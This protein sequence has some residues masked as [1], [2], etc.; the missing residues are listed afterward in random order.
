MRVTHRQN[1]FHRIECWT[2][3]H[4]RRAELWEVGTYI[5]VEHHTD[6]PICQALNFQIKYLES[7]ECMKDQ[8]EQES[9][10]WEADD[11]QR[12]RQRPNSPHSSSEPY[13]ESPSSLDSASSSPDPASGMTADGVEADN[14]TAADSAFLNHLDALW[15][16]GLGNVDAENGFEDFFDGNDESEVQDANEDVHGFQPYLPNPNQT[17]D[18]V[19]LAD[20]AHPATAVP[21]ADA[22]RSAAAAPTAD[23]L[24]NSYIRVV[25]TNG[26]HHLAMVT[27]QCQGEHRIPLDLVTNNLLP[28]SFT[29]IRTLFTVQVLDYFRLCNLELKA[30]A[31]QFYQLIRRVTSPM[32]PAEVVNLYH[33]LRRMSRL[34]RWM[35]RLKWAGYGHNQRDPLTPEPGTLANFC[36]ACP[37][38]GINIPEN[39]KDDVNR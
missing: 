3:T 14:E 7:F 1:P 20:A 26:I 30:S 16:Q 36:P 15:C 4:F 13:H 6:Q 31:Y 9:A 39:W 10:N 38:V 25:H 32:R 5:L 35:K 8:A 24:N 2:G 33:E 27:C 23:A 22:A 34:W 12:Q 29:N 21:L 11:R 17:A 37:Q 18:A 28:T 19:P